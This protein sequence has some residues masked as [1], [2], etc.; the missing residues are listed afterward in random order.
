M[1]ARPGP[2][3]GQPAMVVPTAISVE[4]RALTHLESIGLGNAAFISMGGPQAHG[5]SKPLNERNRLIWSTTLRIIFRDGESRFHEH[6]ISGDYN[7]ARGD[8][9]LHAWLG[10]RSILSMA[11]GRRG[12]HVNASSEEGGLLPVAE[13]YFPRNREREK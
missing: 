2:C 13:D 6:R 7:P 11:P 4:S 3:G 8:S 9:G 12:K 10:S 1:S 5:N